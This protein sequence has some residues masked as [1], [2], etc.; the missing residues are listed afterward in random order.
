VVLPGLAMGAFVFA[1]F[2]NVGLGFAVH[3]L[4]SKR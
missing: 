4:Y 1:L 3:G 2:I